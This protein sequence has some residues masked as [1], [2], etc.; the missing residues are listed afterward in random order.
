M[1]VSITTIRTSQSSRHIVDCF[2]DSR[3]MKFLD[4]QTDSPPDGFLHRTTRANPQRRPHILLQTSRHPWRSKRM[5]VHFMSLFYSKQPSHADMRDEP[6]RRDVLKSTR[7]AWS[8]GPCFK[9][10][11]TYEARHTGT[12]ILVS[13]ASEAGW[14]VA[15]V[16]RN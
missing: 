10:A 3:W 7:K 2:F 14:L 12:Y 9:S 1:T 4:L 16:S 8:F 5:K 15:P 11:E 6:Q 13:T